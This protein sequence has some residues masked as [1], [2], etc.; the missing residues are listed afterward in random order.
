LS[1]LLLWKYVK[2]SDF[3]VTPGYEDLFNKQRQLVLKHYEFFKAYFCQSIYNNYKDFIAGDTL[4]YHRIKF[5]Y[6]WLYFYYVEHNLAINKELITKFKRARITKISDLSESEKSEFLNAS[7]YII[8]NFI[9]GEDLL[10]EQ[11]KQIEKEVMEI[12]WE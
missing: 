5:L 9:W 7:N 4:T 10:I 1:F 8:S 2:E 12:G 6:Y 11:F 3:I